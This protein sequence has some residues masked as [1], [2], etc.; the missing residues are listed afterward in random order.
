MLITHWS[1]LAVA[2]MVLCLLVPPK[3]GGWRTVLVRGILLLLIPLSFV[4]FVDIHGFYYYPDSILYDT[5]ER[6]GL[7][8]EKVN[9][10]S[11]DGTQLSGWFVPA[12][13]ARSP[14]DAKGTVVHMHGNA[15]NMTSHWAF[16]KWLPE[17]GFNV[18]LFDYRGYGESGGHPS[19]KGVFEDSVSALDYVRAR[20]DIDA[21]RLLV[22][23]Q[24]LGG[25]NAIAAVGASRE[26]VRAVA[27]EAAFFSNSRI[28]SD[29]LPGMGVFMNDQWSAENYIGRLAPIPI[30]FFH[31]TAD[32]IVPY[33]HSLLLVEKAGEPKRLI[34]IEG[35]GHME[36]MM[37]HTRGN[38]YRNELVEF[39]EKALNQ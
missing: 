5:P 26:G 38:T 19:P 11:K 13:G 2:L 1:L 16:V 25:S 30:L 15:Q 23:G 36:T 21:T 14:R 20:P 8:Y 31:G 9:F 34:T 12:V 32:L 4:F 39:Y 3:L 35:G 6:T 29:V 27:V 37:H 33:R 10:F 28:A 18:F 7:S 22:F 17:R 24:S